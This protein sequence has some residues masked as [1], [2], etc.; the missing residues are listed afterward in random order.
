MAKDF[1]SNRFFKIEIVNS[2]STNLRS[3][4][5]VTTVAE[6][7]ELVRAQQ[8][9]GRRVGLVPTMGALHAG[10]LSLVRRSK[11]ECDFAVVSIFVNPKQFG[12]QE[13]F[14]KYPRNLDAD[15][16]K[17]AALDVDLVFAP[18]LEQMYPPGFNTHVEVIGLTDIWEGAVRPSHFRGVTTVVLKLFQIAPADRA[19]FGQKDYQQ[20][21]VVRRMATDLNLPTDVVVCPTVRE[22]D[23]LRIS[24]RNQYLS[25]DD[26][27]RAV[28]LSKSLRIARERYA[29]GERDASKIHEAMKSTI[30]AE[31]GVQVDYAAI[32]DPDTLDEL[33]HIETSA[34]ALVAARVGATRLIDNEILRA[35]TMSD[36]R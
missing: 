29:A 14:L 35:E 30:A 8:L 16:E 21:L 33:S 15:L 22:P 23:G 18:T 28:V 1:A 10:H 9:E 2:P 17:L 31:P 6:T 32:V 11:E 7:F 26:R 36:K 27:R 19:Y 12:P 4:L 20:S 5:V 24:S 34:V 13:D 3:P 25:T